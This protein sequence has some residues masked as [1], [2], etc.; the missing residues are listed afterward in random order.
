MVWGIDHND[1]YNICYKYL[2]FSGREGWGNYLSTH[3]NPRVKKRNMGEPQNHNDIYNICYQYLSF[4]GCIEESIPFD[5]EK[6]VRGHP[7]DIGRRIRKSEWRFSSNCREG[8]EPLKPKWHS[9]AMLHWWESK[10]IVPR[11]R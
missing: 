5:I 4:Y 1:I 3:P 11:T 8:K 2:S 9:N 10:D 6:R 7:G